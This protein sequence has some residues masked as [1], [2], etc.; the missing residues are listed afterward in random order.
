MQLR[1]TALIFRNE[2]LRRSE[3]FIR[4]QAA[5]LRSYEAQYVGLERVPNGLEIAALPILLNNNKNSEPSR[6]RNL[7]YRQ[8]GFA[9]LFHRRVA[10]LNASIVHAH[11]GPDGA[12]AMPLAS[13]LNLP[14]IVTLHGFD[15]TSNLSSWPCTLGDRIYLAK[16]PLLARKTSLFICVSQ[17]IRQAAIEKGLPPEKLR[18]HYIGIDR[19]YFSPATGRRDPA[20]ILF[21]GRLV[22]KKGCAHLLRALSRLIRECPQAHA[23]I[24][25]DGPERCSLEAQA[26]SASLP[27]SFM[28]SQPPEV[29]RNW[30]GRARVFCGPS[31]TAANGD[32]EGLGMVFAEAQA[33]G[34]PVV[35][36]LHGGVPEVVKHGATGLLAPE[37]DDESLAEHLNK[38][39]KCDNTWKTFSK[40]GP[41]W[42]ESQFDLA[43]QTKLLEDIYS[44]VLAN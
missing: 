27:C 25:G 19:T 40:N 17:F 11:F 9:P 3:T 14:L 18:V 38:L 44:S 26:S 41:E 4:A 29:I 1:K 37:G 6:L 8:F 35:S 39:I 42:I 21:V 10:K 23:V 7:A 24:I 28:G 43:K 13:S 22:E 20:L 31:R 5:A 34:L 15:I 30:L 12:A 16:F 33:T 2:I 32:S 36:F